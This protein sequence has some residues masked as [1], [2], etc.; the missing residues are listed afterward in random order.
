MIASTVAADD[1]N[2]VK[3][4]PPLIAGEDEIKL[5]VDAFDDVMADA[6]EGRGLIMEV[7]RTVARSALRRQ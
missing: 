6:H 5:F 4:L 7:G 3:L 1:V 2:V